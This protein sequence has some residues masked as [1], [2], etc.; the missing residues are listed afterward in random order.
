MMTLWCKWFHRKY[1]YS[2]KGAVGVEGLWQRLRLR[3]PVWCFKCE[4]EKR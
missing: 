1:H 2:Y 3:P 4:K